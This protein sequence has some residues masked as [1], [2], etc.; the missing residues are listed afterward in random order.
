MHVCRLVQPEDDPE[1]ISLRR[2]ARETDVADLEAALPA[3]LDLVLHVHVR[4][5]RVA[6]LLCTPWISIRNYDFV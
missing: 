3:G 2:V 6:D 1:Q 4:V 5:R